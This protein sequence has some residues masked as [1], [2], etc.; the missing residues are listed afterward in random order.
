MAFVYKGDGMPPPPRSQLARA[1]YSR[2]RDTYVLAKRF[3]NRD[4]MRLWGDFAAEQ[5]NMARLIVADVE[6]EDRDRAAVNVKVDKRLRRAERMVTK[7]A[8]A[9]KPPKF[10]K[11]RS[12]AAVAEIEKALQAGPVVSSFL[13]SADP[14]ER[15]MARKY[16]GL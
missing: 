4:C 5:P 11:V 1:E 10:K 15:E 6:A 16:V 7:A 2:Q 14:A 3:K 12:K 9:G 8:K 13:R